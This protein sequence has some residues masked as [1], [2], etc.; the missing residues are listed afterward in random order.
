MHYLLCQMIHRASF[1]ICGECLS[2]DT[3]R[4][5]M[6]LCLKHLNEALLYFSPGNSLHERFFFNLTFYWA[7]QQHPHKRALPQNSKQKRM[8]KRATF[9]PKVE[10]CVPWPNGQSSAF[11]QAHL[12]DSTG[13]GVVP[14]PRL[15]SS[16]LEELFFHLPKS[17]LQRFST[18]SLSS[19]FLFLQASQTLGAGNAKQQ[20][21]S[22]PGRKEQQVAL[23]ALWET[24]AFHLFTPEPAPSSPQLRS[25]PSTL[26]RLI[27]LQIRYRGH[28]GP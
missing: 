25:C 27:L 26:W 20:S 17:F 3:L 8:I 7:C 13:S 9:Y 14:D 22:D 21:P 28:G 19:S 12:T 5:V 18:M 2:Y 15:T 4:L 24:P 10:F 6:Q 11:F 23:G 1:L 16:K